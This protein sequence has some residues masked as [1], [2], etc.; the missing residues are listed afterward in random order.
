MSLQEHLTA[1]LDDLGHFLD[2]NGTLAMFT[3]HEHVHTAEHADGTW[4][5]EALMHTH[6]DA[7][8][9]VP[10]GPQP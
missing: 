4:F 9:P 1:K 5:G 6:D 10:K 2:P 8:R 3:D 7:G